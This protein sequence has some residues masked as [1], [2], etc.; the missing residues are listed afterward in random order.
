MD[1]DDGKPPLLLRMVDDS[2]DLKF[3]LVL[4]SQLNL[5]DATI[6]FFITSDL[7]FNGC[8]GQLYVHLSEE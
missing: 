6:Q 8:V 3:M 7:I 2:D 5:L 4:T 1:N